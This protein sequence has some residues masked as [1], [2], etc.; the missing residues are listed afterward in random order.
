MIA[1]GDPDS[2]YAAMVREVLDNGSKGIAP[3]GLPT[4]EL[5]GFCSRLE[6]FEGP[7]A[8]K[9]PGLE[10]SLE[11]AQAE[12]AWYLSGTNCIEPL[13]KFS[14]VWER[15]S[16]DGKTANSA[17]GWPLFGWHPEVCL[18]QWEWCVGKLREDPDS[19]QA[20]ANLNLPAHKRS[21]TKDFP[22]TVFLQW[23]L[24]G[25]KLHAVACMR[26]N[27]LFLGFRNDLYC[28]TGLAAEMAKELSVPTGSY[29]HF[30]SSLHA[31]DKDLEKLKAGLEDWEAR[32]G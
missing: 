22:C 25:G 7:Q 15:F 1:R 10:T 13:G 18:D 28:F 9:V 11:Y 19:R 26:S 31:Y 20:V 12:L 2:L 32:H 8:V 4:T 6:S 29:T 21:K 3:R 14:K 30:A 5:L 27:D 16:D 17:Y 23:L 24:R